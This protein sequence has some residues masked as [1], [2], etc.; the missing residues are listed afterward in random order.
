MFHF[1]PRTSPSPRSLPLLLSK[2]LRYRERKRGFVLVRLPFFLVRLSRASFFLLFP[3]RRHLSPSRSRAHT[4][5]FL[6]HAHRPRLLSF[7]SSFILCYSLMFFTLFFPPLP[8]ARA[9]TT[10]FSYDPLS[11]SF[12]PPVSFHP[13]PGR[14]L[15]RSS[16]LQLAS[17]FLF[18][19]ISLLFTPLSLSRPRQTFLASPSLV[20]APALCLS[21]CGSFSPRALQGD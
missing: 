21:L 20:D 17:V 1:V 8:L 14:K 4:I 3:Y 13:T 5:L 16:S 12:R 10:S 7:S 9:Y 15:T 19:L 11:H 18:S 6:F 2:P